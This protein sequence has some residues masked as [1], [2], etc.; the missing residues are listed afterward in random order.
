MFPN[1]R[2]YI[3]EFKAHIIIYSDYDV[4]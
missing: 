1:F 2:V 3:V 4:V